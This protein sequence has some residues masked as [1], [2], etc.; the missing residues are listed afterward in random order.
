[1]LITKEKCKDYSDTELVELTLKKQDYFYCLIKRYEYSLLRYIRR[2]SSTSK[3]DAEDILQEVF[4]SAYQ[5]LNDFDKNLKFS[6]WIYRITHNKT[7]SYWRKIRVRPKEVFSSEY[8]NE[9]LFNLIID[10]KNNPLKNIE[11]KCSEKQI[12][13]I[14]NSLEE[15]YRDVL[16]LKY[17]ED[18][19]YR[20]ISDIL[21]KPMGTIATLLNRSK[22]KFLSKI[23]ENN[24]IF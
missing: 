8:E 15:K 4:I 13:F 14:I 20:E 5:N 1:M 23:K 9:G 18:K 22:K 12:Q 24:I 16:I 3:E 2:I 7:V 17:L 6:S 19:S 11:N 10:E 21:K